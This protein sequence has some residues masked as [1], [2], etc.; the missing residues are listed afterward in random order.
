MERRSVANV[1]CHHQLLMGSSREVVF[2]LL[3][4]ET[5]FCCLLFFELCSVNSETKDDNNGVHTRVEKYA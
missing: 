3:Q 5:H 4:L 1:V 2:Q